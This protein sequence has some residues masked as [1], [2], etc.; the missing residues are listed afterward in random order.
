M[1]Y[2]LHKHWYENLQSCII[3]WWPQYH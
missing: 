2:I 3:I 1:R